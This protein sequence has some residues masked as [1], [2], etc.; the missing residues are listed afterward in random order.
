M[1]KS[2][3]FKGF[4]VFFCC[5]ILLRYRWVKKSLKVACQKVFRDFYKQKEKRRVFLKTR[6]DFTVIAS[7]LFFGIEPKPEHLRYVCHNCKR[8]GVYFFHDAL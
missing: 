8:F 6:R 3:I 1:Q 7:F 5:K 4:F 2:L